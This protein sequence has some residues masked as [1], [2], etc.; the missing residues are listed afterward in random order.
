MSR[1]INTH[2]YALQGMTDSSASYGATIGS[3]SFSAK[4]SSL[5]T[6]QGGQPGFR[7]SRTIQKTVVVGGV[8]HVV[9]AAYTVFL[10]SALVSSDT[11]NVVA[12]LKALIAEATF[13]AGVNNRSLE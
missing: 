9:S 8:P 3:D 2:A 6:K 11:T 10:P 4:F 5:P 13:D 12:E 1:T 7:T